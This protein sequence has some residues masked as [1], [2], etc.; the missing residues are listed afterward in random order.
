MNPYYETERG[1]LFCGD[2][3]E[4]MP[5]LTEK[6]DLVLA[7]PQYGIGEAAGKNKSRGN[8]SGKRTKKNPLGKHIPATD[9]G[10]LEWDNAIP[11][12]EVFEL[13]FKLSAHQMI[14]GGNY[15]AEYLPNS[16]C[17]IV[18]DK[19]NGKTDFADAELIFTSFKKAVR[20]IK[21]RWNGML[22]QSMK[23]K[24][25][26]Y[27]PTQKPLGLMEILLDCY[28]EENAL[29]LDPFGGSGTTGVACENLKRRWILIEKEERYCEIAAKRIEAA[30]SQKSFEDYL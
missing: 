9:Y 10:N 19:D 11:S 2:C 27:H 7:D 14:F 26:R 18:W 8:F 1:R 20:I 3:L 23:R 5:L 13:I 25:K 21:W 22:Q 16:S 6:A 4:V 29:I 30:A 28:S 15:F 24:E 17:W 12:R